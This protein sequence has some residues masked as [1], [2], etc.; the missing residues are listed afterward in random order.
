MGEAKVNVRASALALGRF[1]VAE[2][3]RATGLNPSSIQSE[4]QRMKRDG[5]LTVDDASLA[6]RGRRG[7]PKVYEVVA[8]PD[9]LRRLVASIEAFRPLA[10]PPEEPTSSEYQTTRVL[11]DRAM[12]AAPDRRADLLREAELLLE[13]A[14]EAEVAP[15]APELVRAR[16]RFERGRLH[17]LRK[18]YDRAEHEFNDLRT[19]FAD[20]ADDSMVRLI[21]E[22]RWAVTHALDAEQAL[23]RSVTETAE[24]LVSDLRQGAVESVSAAGSLLAETVAKL[25]PRLHE[26]E[27]DA[28]SQTPARAK[29]YQTE[30]VRNGT[31]ERE[32]PAT[33]EGDW[34]RQL[35]ARVH[36]H[37]AARLVGSPDLEE[38]DLELWRWR[39]DI[40]LQLKHDPM[41]VR[42]MERI[43]EDELRADILSDV[44]CGIRKALPK[45]S[46]P[47]ANVKV[48][49]RWIY[50]RVALSYPDNRALWA[51][52]KGWIDAEP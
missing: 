43:P 9:A 47:S 16:L 1:T 14:V 15:L 48:E 21:D 27:I 5:L 35:A 7:V 46:A 31:L 51:L 3:G 4:L 18:Q 32:A 38:L 6:S 49:L 2:I 42:W 39:T 33:T 26:L 36:E 10:V 41:L 22:Y 20:I 50:L 17:F 37:S 52:R 19:F 30:S 44:L 8:E 13:E 29:S 28:T 34:R 24:R 12:V 25:L 11:L 45:I 23:G 40:L